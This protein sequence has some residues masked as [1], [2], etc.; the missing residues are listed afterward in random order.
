MNLKLRQSS[1]SSMVTVILRTIGVVIALSVAV[2]GVGLLPKC[3]DL[4]T[5]ALAA[6]EHRSLSEALKENREAIRVNQ[7]T[8]IR[9]LEG[10]H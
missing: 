5:R 2:V 3:S 9:I 4:Q 10:H 7:A 6:G 1:D 8:I